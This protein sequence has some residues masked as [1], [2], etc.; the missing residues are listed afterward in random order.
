M[1]TSRARAKKKERDDARFS[2]A[3]TRASGPDSS[4]TLA[5]AA[6]GREEKRIYDTSR[7]AA[8]DKS[9]LRS[10]RESRCRA[11]WLRSRRPVIEEK[12]RA[13]SFDYYDSVYPTDRRQRVGGIDN[14]I[15]RAT[16]E[17]ILVTAFATL[18]GAVTLRRGTPAYGLARGI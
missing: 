16:R 13:R 3:R 6:L 8:I 18:Y 14:A 15:L 12:E 9:I 1:R 10:A 4:L 7:K 17:G 5:S 2:P 11:R